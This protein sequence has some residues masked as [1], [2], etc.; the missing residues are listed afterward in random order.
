MRPAHI[1]GA[2]IGQGAEMAKAPRGGFAVQP[3]FLAALNGELNFYN[4]QIDFDAEA[5][6]DFAQ[7]LSEG[8]QTPCRDAT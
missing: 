2:A 4:E 8:F 7:L 5:Q 6:V 3:L 1:L